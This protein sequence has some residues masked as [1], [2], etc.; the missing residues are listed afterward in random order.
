MYCW[1]KVRVTHE[2]SWGLDTV[3]Y[4]Y[5]TV[6]GRL[7]NQ[8]AILETTHVIIMIIIMIFT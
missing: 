5:C 1:V 8:Y 7:R 4:V 6:R 2:Y 3:S